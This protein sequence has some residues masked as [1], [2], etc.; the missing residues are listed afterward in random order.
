M[1]ETR[2]RQFG[3]AEAIQVNVCPWDAD[4]FLVRARCAPSTVSELRRLRGVEVWTGGDGGHLL[5]VFPPSRLTKVVVALRPPK[6]T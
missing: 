4:S 2:K 3:F 1:R 6:S 5:A